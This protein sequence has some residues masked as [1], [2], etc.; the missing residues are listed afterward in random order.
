[1]ILNKDRP[2]TVDNYKKLFTKRN[3]INLT[4]HTNV[5]SVQGLM[6]LL[7]I[8]NEENDTCFWSFSKKDIDSNSIELYE[9]TDYV[10]VEDQEEIRLFEI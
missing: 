4:K 1:M 5:I 8:I 6:D 9:F 2:I 7:N 10:W 3:E